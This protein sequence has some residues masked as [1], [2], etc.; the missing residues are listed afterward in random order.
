MIDYNVFVSCFREC[1]IILNCME[2]LETGQIINFHHNNIL[3]YPGK[4]AFC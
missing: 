1:T 3:V 2:N 4:S